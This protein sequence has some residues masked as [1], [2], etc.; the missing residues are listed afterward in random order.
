MITGVSGLIGSSLY[1]AAEKSGKKVL[2]IGRNLISNENY[3]STD[4]TKNRSYKEINRL[5]KVDTL[6]HT[7]A[8]VPKD[9]F[10][11]QDSQ[12][13]EVNR[14]ITDNTLNINASNIIALSSI[15]IYGSDVCGVIDENISPNP[16]SAYAKSKLDGE[17]VLRSSIKNRKIL[18]IPGVFAQSEKMVLFMIFAEK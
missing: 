16:Q 9:K 4:L 1:K 3:F 15:S 13:I 6:I 17:R 14:K 11:Y 10:G 8:M 18:R 12:I 2:G 5:F 7:A